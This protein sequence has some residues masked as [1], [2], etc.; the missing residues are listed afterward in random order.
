MLEAGRRSV[1]LA[2]LT[3]ASESGPFSQ[4]LPTQKSEPFLSRRSAQLTLASSSASRW[5]ARRRPRSP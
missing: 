5:T 3:N 1:A 2:E 4:L